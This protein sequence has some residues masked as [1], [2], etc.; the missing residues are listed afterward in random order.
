MTLTRAILLILG[1]FAMALPAG[2]SKDS[3]SSSPTRVAPS[4]AASAG[5]GQRRL[6]VL[7]GS[8]TFLID[9]PLEKI[10][11]RSTKV[12]GTLHL[13]PQNLKASKGQIEVDL[14]DL[15]TETFQDA[16][17]NKSQTGH[18]KNWLEIGTDVEEKRREEN[19]W[20]RFTIKSIDDD[21]AKAQAADSPAKAQTGG[22]GV[23]NAAGRTSVTVRATGEMW[24][25]G[26]SA[27]KTVIATVTFAGPA[28]AP[29][30]VRVVTSQPIAV[31]LKE[32]DVKP[33]DLAG[34]F[35]AGALEKVGQ[36]IDDSVQIS[37]DLT[38]K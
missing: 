32:H 28:E 4:A 26:V 27:P 19:R 8:A 35:L 15:K 22:T 5:V 30:S 31:S 13:D 36:K 23:V 10:K 3:P 34:K 29:T 20:A 17:K 16:E 21:P 2:C 11:G 12:R 6:E 18:S 38:A 1:P 33:R 24:I 37:L 9:A 25:H 7:E 14:D